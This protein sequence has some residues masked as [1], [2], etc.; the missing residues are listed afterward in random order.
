MTLTKYSIGVG[1]RFARQ[2]VAQVHACQLAVRHGVDVV[3]V[4]NKSHREHTIIGSR[5]ETVRAAAAGAVSAT[6]WPLPYHVDAD[7]I[8]AETVDAFIPS[9]DFFTI[10]V[11]DFIGRA[12][13]RDAVAAFVGNH[14]EWSKPL[15][16]EG[17]EHPLDTNPSA[18]TRIAN[19]YL[20]AIQEAARVYRHIE[21]RKRPAP[22]ITEVSL[23]ETEAPQTPLEL[24]VILAALADEQV[25]LQTVAPRFVG[26]FNKGVDYQGD[27]DQFE[28]QFRQCLAVVR[29]AVKSYRLPNNLKLSVHS[30]SDKFSLYPAMRCAINHYDAGLHL[31][32]AG[33]TWLE[34]L[35]GIAESGGEGLA[36]ARDIY[37][38]ALAHADEL[39]RPYAAVVDIDRTRL[40][41]L[42][43]VQRWTPEQFVAA[44]RHDPQCSEFN[45]HLRQLLHVG[46]K[47][48]ADLGSRFLDQL[49]A[50]AP[51]IA[52]HVTANLYHR[53]IKPLFVSEI[54]GNRI[55]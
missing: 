32:T 8:R 37:G 46:Y 50:C 34:E 43:E 31:K 38:E 18:A 53:H 2:A 39:C 51:S 16:M 30:G 5:P 23:D 9:C 25:P 49:A 48:A 1:D 26:R 55:D 3:P 36:L 4:W 21:S 17:L 11:A 6:G 24:L 42:T 7:H 54:S 27:P 52:R 44:L 12:T 29:H 35:T 19:H 22:F 15:E 45:P 47:V 10:D 40:P 41:A 33:T 14:P 28:V 13:D 20:R